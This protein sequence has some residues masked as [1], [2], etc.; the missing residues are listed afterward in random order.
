MPWFGWS[1]G[2]KNRACRYLLHHYGGP[3]L[4]EKL[5]LDQLSVDLYKGK[6]RITNVCLDVKVNNCCFGVTPTSLNLFVCYSRLN[7]V[8]VC[9]KDA[10]SV[11]TLERVNRTSFLS[12]F[13]ETVYSRLWRAIKHLS[14]SPRLV[15]HGGSVS[16]PGRGSN[17][18][19]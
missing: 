16:G 7:G 6:G 13:S 12:L 19:P 10:G 8:P 18:A 5:S 1:E 11:P 15:V 3:F 2:I 4:L 14:S 9:P 17:F